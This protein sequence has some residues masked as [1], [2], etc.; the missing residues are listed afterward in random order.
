MSTHRGP[1][2]RITPVQ[3]VL[4]VV[5]VT[6]LVVGILIGQKEP[7][8]AGTGAVAAAAGCVA[9]EGSEASDAGC[10]T[11]RPTPT[12]GVISPSATSDGESA[13]AKAGVAPS[14]SAIGAATGSSSGSGSTAGEGATP[15]SAGQPSRPT[16][17][18][19]ESREDQDV[20]LHLP[21]VT[22]PT[23]ILECP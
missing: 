20:S 8:P 12:A 16:R 4:G 7:D 22:L 23:C 13:D 14:T 19:E 6:A 1:A 9:E 11:S 17:P 3:I 15:S 18:A 21:P 5:G 10:P 2:R